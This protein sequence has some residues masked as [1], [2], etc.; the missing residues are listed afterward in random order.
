MGYPYPKFCLCAFLGPYLGVS[1]WIPWGRGLRVGRPIGWRDLARSYLNLIRGGSKD[2]QIAAFGPKDQTIWE[3]PKIRGTFL[4][5]P[6][7]KDP[8]IQ[9]TIS[10]FWPIL[11]PRDNSLNLS[12]LLSHSPAQ[13]PNGPYKASTRSP[14]PKP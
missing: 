10:G 2:S 4:G 14:F 8:T 5:G 12:P 7:K 1:T 3:F 13:G 6:Y 9:G 11:I